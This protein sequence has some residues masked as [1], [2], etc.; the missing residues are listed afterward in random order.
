MQF[1]IIERFK[2]RNP[3]P[4]YQRLRDDGRVLPDGVTVAS[5]T[6]YAVGTA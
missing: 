6:R 5:Y 3:K 2:D 1:M 4:I